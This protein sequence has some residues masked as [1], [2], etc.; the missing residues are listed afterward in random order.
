MSFD[1][2]VIILI[3]MC[4][5][6]FGFVVIF[7]VVRNG[8]CVWIVVNIIV[9]DDFCGMKI[10]GWMIVRVYFNCLCENVKIGLRGNENFRFWVVVI[11]LVGFYDIEFDGVIWFEICLGKYCG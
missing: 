9:D 7:V 1:V 5:Y 6:S 8:E 4:N 11:F 10:R 2:D 3:D